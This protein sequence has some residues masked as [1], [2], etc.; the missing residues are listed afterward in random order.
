MSN[1]ST[2]LTFVAPEEA[3]PATLTSVDDVLDSA[4]GSYVCDPYL[5]ATSRNGWVRFKMCE[6]VKAYK[7]ADL[8]YLCNLAVVLRSDSLDRAIS[9]V[10]QLL[11]LMDETPAVCT[12][13]VNGSSKYYADGD[14]KK[15]LVCPPTSVDEALKRYDNCR[16]CDEGDDLPTLVAFVYAHLFVLEYAQASGLC[17]VYAT[18]VH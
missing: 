9:A 17:A 18:H 6:L 10:R 3:V 15:L 13:V 11:A 1:L 12:A 4:L 8:G 2:T 5:Q 7:S 16:W 14:V